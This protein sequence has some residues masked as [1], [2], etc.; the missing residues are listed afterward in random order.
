[1]LQFI[2]LRVA[3]AREPILPFLDYVPGLADFV[4]KR[5]RYVADWV[6]VFYVTVYVEANQLSIHF[7][8]MGQ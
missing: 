2:A 6:R 7:M 4:R 8:F 3:A 5:S 1:M